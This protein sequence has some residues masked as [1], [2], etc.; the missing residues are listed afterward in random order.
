MDEEA[1]YP[2]DQ[3]EQQHKPIQ[4]NPWA[5]PSIQSIAKSAPAALMII[6]TITTGDDN[7][8]DQTAKITAADGQ[9]LE[10][11]HP[12]RCHLDSGLDS[13]FDGQIRAAARPSACVFGDDHGYARKAAVASEL[14][15]LKG[16]TIGDR[17][18][19]MLD[20]CRQR[21]PL[22]RFDGRDASET[23]V[24][25]LAECKREREFQRT[26]LDD[27][28]PCVEHSHSVACASLRHDG[29]QDC[30]YAQASSPKNPEN[31]R[32]SIREFLSDHG[33]MVAYGHWD[34]AACTSYG[35]TAQ[36][37][38]HSEMQQQGS[39]MQQRNAMQVFSL[40]FFL[41]CT[42]SRCSTARLIQPEPLP[43]QAGAGSLWALR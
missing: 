23:W 25:G 35:G 10:A 38:A 2:L 9:A 12:S 33:Q 40:F 6:T 28:P 29:G 5:R 14:W 3:F 31:Q 8:P 20:R 42:D 16:A 37:V 11:N 13:T 24:G 1:L 34:V 30:L 22:V 18:K 43:K 36:Q 4:P 41:P 27:T 39:A 21:R 19:T 32:R 7:G 17:R 26:T 15:T